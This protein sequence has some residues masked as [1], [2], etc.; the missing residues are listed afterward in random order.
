M[1]GA[2]YFN[3]H[4]FEPP[5][6]WGGGRKKGQKSGGGLGSPSFAGYVGCIRMG[7]HGRIPLDTLARLQTVPCRHCQTLFV[8]PVG[9]GTRKGQQVSSNQGGNAKEPPWKSTIKNA[10]A[11][12]P[13]MDS[14]DQKKREQL[15]S[16][17][18]VIEFQKQDGGEDAL[19]TSLKKQAAA[20]EI[21]LA[22]PVTDASLLRKVTQAG[23]KVSVAENDLRQQRL[24]LS[25]ALEAVQDRIEKCKD[26]ELKLEQ[27][28]QV[29]KLARDTLDQK[30]PFAGEAA[31]SPVEV[32]QAMDQEALT[33]FLLDNPEYLAS[34]RKIQM[35]HDGP[36]KLPVGAT[37]APDPIGFGWGSFGAATREA[38]SFGPASVS[39]GVASGPYDRSA[40]SVPIH[41][42]GSHT[43]PAVAETGLGA[44]ADIDEDLASDANAPKVI[45]SMEAVACASAFLAANGINNIQEVDLG[46]LSGQV[47]SARNALGA[48]P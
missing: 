15:S 19:L 36:S 17:L 1:Y 44:S 39:A 28:R 21:E 29:Y 25:K 8:H 6:P 48:C 42:F 7:C 9:H 37:T 45:S 10:E 33:K 47:S 2:R 27:C 43:S 5:P 30:L 22:P 12:A 4:H 32:P 38:E 24:A 26:S 20:L 23:A 31:T 34:V 3:Q 18:A 40:N 16:L 14:K 13:P 46:V 11:K 41:T 35:Q